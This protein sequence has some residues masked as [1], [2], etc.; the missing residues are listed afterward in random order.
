MSEARAGLTVSRMP[1][2][3]GGWFWC[4]ST[5]ASSGVWRG[6]GKDFLRFFGVI[7]HVGG[8]QKACEGY[9]DPPGWLDFPKVLGVSSRFQ[10]PKVGKMCP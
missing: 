7:A 6:L 8:V 9:E 10:I 2:R 5:C 1:P 4:A 3:S